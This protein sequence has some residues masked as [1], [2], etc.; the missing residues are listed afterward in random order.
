MCHSITDIVDT[1]NARL[2]LTL[3]GV[4]RGSIENPQSNEAHTSVYDERFKSS[5][6]CSSRRPVVNGKGAL[7]EQ[8]YEEWYSRFPVE[9]TE[10]QTCHMPARKGRA[11]VGGPERTIHSHLMVGVYV[12]LLPEDEFPGYHEMRQLVAEM[13]RKAAKIDVSAQPEA[14]RI[15]VQIENTTGHSLP[16]GAT[17]DRQVWLEVIVRSETGEVVFESGTLDANGDIRDGLEG[18]SLA[19][20]TD[21]QLVY[22]GQ[23]LLA[24]P[25]LGKEVDEKKRAQIRARVSAGCVGFGLGGI[26]PDVGAKPVLFPWQA[27]AMRR[28]T[29]PSRRRAARIRPWGVGA[30]QILGQHSIPLPNIPTLSL[31]K[32]EL[33]GGLDPPSRHAF[34]HG[35]RCG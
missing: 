11:A 4:Q 5:I 16:S 21:P 9:K 29:A 17:A 2:E 13:L 20:G 32:L 23:L 8:T 33:I 31:R 18:H 6:I 35:H 12:S 14:N 24:V 25:E 1:K 26:K 27:T 19:P 3:D 22:Y 34:V 28:I 7:I 10:C 15:R 30:W